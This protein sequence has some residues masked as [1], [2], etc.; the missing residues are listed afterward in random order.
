VPTRHRRPAAVILRC[1]GP[2]HKLLTIRPAIGVNRFVV[3]REE[4][5]AGGAARDTDQWLRTGVGTEMNFATLPALF[6]EIDAS[7]ASTVD[8]LLGDSPYLFCR[9]GSA[10]LDE[11][12]ADRIGEALYSWHRSAAM[13]AARPKTILVDIR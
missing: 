3:V 2:G 9:C 5:R 11:S 10:M 12:T 8:G 4:G 7:E 1:S 6:R 13:G